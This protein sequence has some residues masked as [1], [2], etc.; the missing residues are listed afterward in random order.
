MNP[1]EIRGRKMH[2]LA[3]VFCVTLLVATLAIAGCGKEEPAPTPARTASPAIQGTQPREGAAPAGADEK[4]GAH[5]P[6]GQPRDDQR[7]DGPHKDDHKEPVAPAEA[8]SGIRLTAEERENIGLKTEVAQVRP[9]EDV[10]KLNGIV[11]PHP[12]R[13]AQVTSRVPG[14]VLDI[15][16][17]LGAWVKRGEDLLE[18]QSV[19][20]ERAELSLIQAENKLALTTVD[21]E[22]AK[23][24]VE[25]GIAARRELLTLENQQRELLNEI[26]SLTRQLILLGL[27]PEEIK[28]I[29]QEKA[30][31]TLHI[32]APLGGTIVERSVVLGQMIEPNAVLMKIIDTSVMIIEG[33]AFEDTLS[34]LKVGQK[35]RVVVSAYPT[36]LFEGKISFISPTVNPTKRTIP[37]WA[38]VRNRRGMLKQDL[39][40]KVYVIV[41]EQ[42]RSL[43]IPVESLISAEGSDF[44]FVERS[45]VYVRAELALGLRNDRFAEVRRGLSP[46]DRVVTDGNRQLYAK[47]LAAKSGGPALGGHPH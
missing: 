44:A 37:I 25:R 47:W 12:D 41:A 20:L 38:E 36:E 33:E 14:K 32:L 9:I 18:V 19:E 3:Q 15:H 45:G 13:V 46:G 17:P 11:K 7:H 35:V 10:R 42:R 31:T 28:R 29:R 39:F 5:P 40:A 27:P 24:L 30:V 4:G 26:E 34:L 2:K 43:T 21:L 6:E 23:K 1:E 22:R 8:V 16:V